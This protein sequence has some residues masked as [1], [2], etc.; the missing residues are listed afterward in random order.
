MDAPVPA[1]SSAAPWTTR[2]L[3]KWMHEHFASREVDAPRVCAEMLLARTFGCERM[4]LYMEA[5]R[6]ASESE[7]A[8][9]REFVR[10]VSA[11]EPVQY[12]VGEAWFFSRAFEVSPMTLIPR[13]A[14]E[15]LVEE[16][17]SFLRVRGGAAQHADKA[18]TGEEARATEAPRKTAVLDLCT[19]TGCIAISIALA[20]GVDAAIVATDLSQEVL[21]LAARNAKRHGAEAR[22]RLACGDLY[23]ALSGDERFDLIAA[24]PPY[25]S[26]REWLELDRNVRDY[27]PARALR[28]G[29]DGLDLVRPVIAGAAARLAPGGLLL[30][31]IGHAQRDAVLEIA[32]ATPGL[33]EV[34]VLDDLEGFHRVLRA[35]AVP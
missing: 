18:A 24:N 11:H 9:L 7:R 32:R 34:E 35:R 21:E 10:R 4:R 14:T 17:V 26:D 13:P 25:V 31:E 6:P 15:R 30:V 12:V 33:G 29:A 2:R 3:L 8:V 19:G 28:G 22:V 1:A 5:E 27:E 23:E 20:K 16:A